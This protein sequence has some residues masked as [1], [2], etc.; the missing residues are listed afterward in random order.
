[1]YRSGLSKEWAYWV[2]NR[3]TG[4]RRNGY[5]SGKWAYWWEMGILN[6]NIG[7]EEY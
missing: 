1:M 5:T 7:W 2:G 3:H 4:N 6:G